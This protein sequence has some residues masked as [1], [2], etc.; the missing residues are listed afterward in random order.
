VRYEALI[1]DPGMVTEELCAFVGLEPVD[2]M[3]RYF[4]RAADRLSERERS[5]HPNIVRPPTKGLRDWRIDM[6]ERDVEAFESIAGPLL[7]ELGYERRFPRRSKRVAAR[8]FVEMRKRDARAAKV[9][10][11]R[12]VRSS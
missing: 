6:P 2:G 8:G 7:S 4:E 3:L 9:A 10:A 5:N 1:D 12:A 11:A